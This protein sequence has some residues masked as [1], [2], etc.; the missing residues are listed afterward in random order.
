MVLLGNLY[1]Q[2]SE[3]D[4]A[5]LKGDSISVLDFKDYE[6]KVSFSENAWCGGTWARWRSRVETIAIRSFSGVQK[7]IYL[8]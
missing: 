6:G 1:Y 4:A 5:V 3:I 2:G 7:A 8:C